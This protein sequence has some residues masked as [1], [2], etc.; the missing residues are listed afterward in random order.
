MSNLQSWLNYTRYLNSPDVFLETGFYFMINAALE[1]RVWAPPVHNPIWPNIYVILVGKAALGKG[2]VTRPVRDMLKYWKFS[3]RDRAD[4]ENLFNVRNKAADEIVA[5]IK[6]TQE[7]TGARSKVPSEPPPLFP[8][9]PNVV[10]FEAFMQEL[11]N[12]VRT[13]KTV[14]GHPMASPNGIYVY[15]PMYFCLEEMINTFGSRADKFANYMLEAFDCGDFD[16]VTKH[17]GQDRIRKPCVSFL[18]G[19]TVAHL[20]EMFTTKIF[21]DGFASRT[22][23]VYEFAPRGFRFDIPTL[24]AGQEADRKQI[25]RQL[26]R[27]SKVFGEVAYEPEALEYLKQYFEQFNTKL[28][29]RPNKSPKLESYYDRKKVHAVKLAM[30]IHFA[31]RTDLVLTLEDVQKAIDY[32][33]RIE[34]N[35]HHALSFG[36]NK[37]GPIAKKVLRFLKSQPIDE[38]FK[39][40]RG[41]TFGNIWIE[42]SNELNKAQMEEC[43]RYGESIEGIENYTEIDRTTG[44]EKTF[45]RFKIPE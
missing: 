43:L 25:L 7:A 33:G 39:K 31:D 22:L 29:N 5:A 28:E 23:F 1:R 17:Q 32:L 6:E 8:T 3:D 10:T 42:F 14:K 21:T 30:A 12:S 15:K 44:K 35:M 37:I 19:A 45:Y 2:M 26:F 34:V 20:S 9:G 24:D 27:L 13:V 18:G 38:T 41:L 11:A 36:D 4:D 16:Y 40:H